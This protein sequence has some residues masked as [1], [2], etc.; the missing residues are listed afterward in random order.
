MNDLGKPTERSSAGLR[1]TLF[2]EID[3]LRQGKGDYNRA[4]AIARLAHQIVSTARLEMEY[5]NRPETAENITV[6]EWKAPK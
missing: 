4:R 6:I 2:H 5:A 3:M 1:E